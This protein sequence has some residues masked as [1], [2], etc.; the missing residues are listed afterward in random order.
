MSTLTKVLIVLLTLASIFLCGIVV[1][2]VAS[3][4]N[5]KAKFDEQVA[6]VDAQTSK[7]KMQENQFNTYMAQAQRTQDELNSKITALE[8]EKAQ[9]AADL[10]T[11]KTSS[12]A[13]QE[14]VSNLAGVVAGLNQTISSMDQSLKLAREELDRIRNDQVRD[15]KNLNE[16]VAAL[17]EKQV[18]LDTLEA[19]K[20]RLLE[21]KSA[22]E[23]QISKVTSGQS[24][25]VT[26]GVVTPEGGNVRITPP[27]TDQVAVQGKVAQINAANK[28]VTLSIGSADGVKE[29]MRFHVV[30]GD[31][32]VCDI[33]V[34]HVDV[35]ESAG[36]IELKRSEPQVGDMVSTTL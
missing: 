5:Y 6:A 15:K 21:Q 8:A 7:F 10:G 12:F 23:D 34:T 29:G 22:L 20:R 9:M 30:R 31:A 32:F 36:T 19:D 2:Y 14:R 33:V 3:A 25:T 26:A 11:A 4:E 1:T 28:L 24:G 17:N 13:A 27:A 35:E 18:Q 16:V